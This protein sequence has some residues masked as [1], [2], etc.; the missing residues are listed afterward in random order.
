MVEELN[1]ETMD[2]VWEWLNVFIPI[3][4]GGNV[5]GSD[6]HCLLVFTF[7]YEY[8]AYQMTWD[9]TCGILFSPSLSPITRSRDPRQTRKPQSLGN[10]IHDR[11]GVASSGDHMTLVRLEYSHETVMW[12]VLDW[13][14]LISLIIKENLVPIFFKGP[15]PVMLICDVM[16]YDLLTNSTVKFKNSEYS[17]G[18]LR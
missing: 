7:C 18:D 1:W 15:F 9:Q 2:G 6:S 17:S 13:L 4:M 5:K 8:H 3:R 12:L 16:I 11:Q 10:E 14:G